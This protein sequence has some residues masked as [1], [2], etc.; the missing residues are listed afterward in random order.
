MPEHRLVYLSLCSAKWLIPD[1][2]G[3]CLPRF[4]QQLPNFETMTHDSDSAASVVPAFLKYGNAMLSGPG[5]T[6]S[7]AI[8]GAA[9]ISLAQSCCAVCALSHRAEG[10][11]KA[12][13]DDA[14]VLFMFLPR[15][16]QF[17]ARGWSVS[18]RG[19]FLRRSRQTP[20]IQPA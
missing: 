11:V 19:L 9:E 13:K 4:V 7:H 2:K 1:E 20:Q 10:H 6:T 8:A 17:A 16:P 12:A 18:S 5:A 3:R 14:T 15:P